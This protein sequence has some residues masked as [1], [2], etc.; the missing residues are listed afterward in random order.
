MIIFHKLLAGIVIKLI[1]I[2]N[3]TIN[4][5]G[6]YGNHFNHYFHIRLNKN[7]KVK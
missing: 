4:I 6:S 2:F 7:T 1:T 3:V 5:F